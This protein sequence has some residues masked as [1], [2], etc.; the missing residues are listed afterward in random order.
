MAGAKKSKNNPDTRNA[1]VKGRMVMSDDCE[2]CTE[3]CGKGRE[4]LQ[5]MA[6]KHQGNGVF[7]RK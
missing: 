7:C 1:Q 6:L 5:R 4:Y 3:K 2:K